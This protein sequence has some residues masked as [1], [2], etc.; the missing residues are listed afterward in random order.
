MSRL[1]AFLGGPVVEKSP[2]S[3]GGCTG[4]IPDQEAKTPRALWPKN[5]SSI[6]TNSI[7]TLKIVHIFK[8]KIRSY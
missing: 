6:V 4:L 2:S 7:M 5:R 8:K 1:W 3:A